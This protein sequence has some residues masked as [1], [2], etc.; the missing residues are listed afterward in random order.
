MMNRKFSRHLLIIILCS[1]P[2]LS[3][4]SFFDFLR[5]SRQLFHGSSLSSTSLRER[6]FY[7]YFLLLSS[8]RAAA[9]GK[10]KWLR[11]LTTPPP[12]QEIMS[13]LVTFMET[14]QLGKYSHGKEKVNINVTIRT[15]S[16]KECIQ[17]F[18][19]TYQQTN[20]NLETSWMFLSVSDY[21][22]T[23]VVM[24]N[25]GYTLKNVVGFPTKTSKFSAN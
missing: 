4:H 9:G 11:R 8:P 14:S 6:G 16:L 7:L 22:R 13:A 2:S 21:A 5:Y 17:C 25:T 12:P 23:F 18:S 10:A 24:E 15:G 1:R 3:W 20:I 19:D